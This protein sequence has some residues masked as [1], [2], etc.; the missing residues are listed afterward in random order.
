MDTRIM[1]VRHAV[2]VG[3]VAL[4]LGAVLEAAEPQLTTIKSAPPEGLSTEIRQSLGGSALRVAVDGEVVTELWLRREVPLQEAA[5]TEL[6]VSFGRLGSGTLI[7]VVRLDRPWSDY[8]NNPVA[9]GVYTLRYAVEPADG[10]HMGVSLYRDFLL[11]IPVSEDVSVEVAWSADELTGKSLASTGTPHPAVLALFPVW[12]EVTEPALIRNDLDQWT[13][14][15]PMGSISP[16][17]GLV[18]Q[19]HGEI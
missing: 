14:A 9:A 2:A 7:G 5:N 3:V 11:L 16:T 17:P 10:N 12:E 15:V 4:G 8:K 6:G 13:L 1:S 19:G 18:V